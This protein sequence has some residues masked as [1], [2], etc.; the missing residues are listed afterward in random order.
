M[1]IG[2]APGEQEDQKGRPFI[3]RAGKRLTELLESIGLDRAKVF[4]TNVCK[5]RPPNNRDPW[6]KEIR[7]CRRHLERQIEAINSEVIVPLG[8]HSLS[9]FLKHAT[10]A[11]AHGNVF[12]QNG[13]TIF[14]M[15]HPAAGF[16]NPKLRA[17]QEADFE[18]LAG[19]IEE[20][21]RK[22]DAYDV[23]IV[24]GRHLLYR[25]ADVHKDLSV[26]LK[27]GESIDTGGIYGFLI[28]LMRIRSHYCS[29]IIVAWEGTDNFRYKLYPE[30]KAHRATPTDD[31]DYA[32]FRSSLSEQEARLRKVLS[33]M[34]VV[35]YRGRECEADDVIGTLSRILAGQHS[36]VGIYSGDSDLR[37]LV[38]DRVTVIAPAWGSGVRDVVYTPTTVT[39]KYGIE[40]KFIADLKALAGDHSDNIPG[41]K[42]VGEKTATKLISVYGDVESII[43]SAGSGRVGW[44]VHE[45]F[46]LLVSSQAD[47]LKLF[48]KLTT[49]KKDVKLLFT[50]P[51]PDADKLRRLLL[52]YKFTTLLTS[53]S[54][55]ILASGF[56][57]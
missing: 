25:N 33:S 1:F 24:D 5:C 29:R 2:E 32:L 6:P 30:Y 45:K 10:I 31:A 14:P 49:V 37:Q 39:E 42:G 16:Y 13:R 15:Y 34:G 44:P 28:S 18:T 43:K 53:S 56:R 40:P 21:G 7:A 50:R 3:G 51:S 52:K 38:T 48:K 47:Q 12:V 35:Q 41:V 11:T 22:M 23:L 55:Q 17:T 46:A 8:R 27:T 19:L 57:S 4:I 9:H 20:A 54:Y 26:K 36:R